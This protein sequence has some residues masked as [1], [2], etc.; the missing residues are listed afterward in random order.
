MVPA[1][2]VLE[3]NPGD[4]Y[5]ICSDGLTNY[6]HVEEISESLRPPDTRGRAGELIRLALQRGSQD[7]I[8]CIVA[9]VIEGDSGYNIAL[10]VGALGLA[11][12]TNV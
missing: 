1:F 2:Q 11:E 4:R 10:S 7:N 3:T 8:T 12:V 9:D 6:V 5:L